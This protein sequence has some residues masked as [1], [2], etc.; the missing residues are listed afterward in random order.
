MP[1]AN[2]ISP[3]F[4]SIEVTAFDVQHDVHDA[5]TCE[6][7]RDLLAEHAVVCIRLSTGLTDDELQAVASM[8]GP[9]KDPL[10]RTVDGSTIRYGE[11]RQVIDAG[12]VMTDEIREQLGDG[13]LGGDD[14]RPGLFQFFHTDDSYV[15]RP[16]AATV[17]HA[18]DLPVGG[19]GDTVFL[20][21]RV[22]FDQ[23]DPDRRAALL[24]L[25]AV[26]AYDNHDAFPPRPSASGELDA[27]VEVSHPFVRAHPRNGRPALYM[28]LD[29]A[30][31]VVELPIDEGRV[32]LQELQDHAEAHAPR[33]SHSWHPHD[34]LMWDDSSVQHRASGDFEVG[35]P[36]RFWRYLV[37]GPVPVGAT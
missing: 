34:V 18:R 33:Y 30:T 31:H 29:R 16:A 26:H 15:E 7:L 6:W 13:S 19:G 21:M 32:L 11:R 20:D 8:I 27:L 24:G 14:L 1:G 37:E 10:A 23:L 35:Q 9:I 2:V 28:D 12:F 4:G 36:R 22:A 5:E 3:S 17:L 25:H